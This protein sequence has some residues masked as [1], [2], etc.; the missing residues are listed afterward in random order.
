M[1]EV[2]VLREQETRLGVVVFGGN[3][4]N[5]RVG[6]G[7]RPLRD[8]EDFR[9]HTLELPEGVQIA[10]FENINQRDTINR[11]PVHWKILANTLNEVQKECDGVLVLNGVDAMPFDGPAVTYALG[12]NIR[13]PILFVASHDELGVEYSDAEQFISTAHTSLQRA[14]QGRIR[15]VMV[16]ADEIGNLIRA[17]RAVILSGFGIPIFGITPHTNE[18]EV[19]DWDHFYPSARKAN[20]SINLK[21][22]VLAEF[23]DNIG[24][25]E[26]TPGFNPRKL[27]EEMRAGYYSALIIN[28]T[29]AGR[30]PV[31]LLGILGPDMPK[32]PIIIQTRHIEDFELSDME[33]IKAQSEVKSGG[34]I[35]TFDMTHEAVWV[36]TA[37]LLAQPQYRESVEAF[38]QGFYRDFGDITV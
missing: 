15:E 27:L 12:D 10:R 16:L 7:I 30:L 24:F 5:V 28:S 36:K 20:E 9:A 26:W 19:G 31:N 37:W 38:R 3:I 13:A 33:V 17:S 32:I 25:V 34:A 18:G 14:H 22:E 21:S 8:I 1:A 23:N 2:E 6:D 35:P 4:S 29:E 11:Q